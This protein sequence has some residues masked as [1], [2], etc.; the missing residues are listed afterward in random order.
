M[1]A[2]VRLKR[3]ADEL[4]FEGL[5]LACKKKKTEDNDIQVTPVFKFAGTVKYQVNMYFLSTYV[6][7]S[8]IMETFSLIK[9]YDMKAFTGSSL[10]LYDHQIDVILHVCGILTLDMFDGCHSR[11]DRCGNDRNPAPAGNRTLDMQCIALNFGGSY[12]ASSLGIRSRKYCLWNMLITPK[13]QINCLKYKTDL[14]L[15]W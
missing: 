5:V 14:C 4:S 8:N 7:M 3:R 11:S 15:V 6:L 13:M 2:V 9:V 12:H 10:G 1:A